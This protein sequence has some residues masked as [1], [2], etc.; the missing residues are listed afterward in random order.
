MH[1]STNL[2][3]EIETVKGV[4]Q[5]VYKLPLRDIPG[6]VGQTGFYGAEVKDVVNRIII[7][8]SANGIV[9]RDAFIHLLTKAELAEPQKKV[10]VS[11]IPI[12]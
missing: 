12:R 1:P 7:G 8:P 2:T 11:G 5:F 4:P 9:I 10:F 3:K 6:E